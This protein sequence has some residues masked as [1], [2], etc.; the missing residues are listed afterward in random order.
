[1]AQRRDLIQPSGPLS[2]LVHASLIRRVRSVRYLAQ[3]GTGELAGSRCTLT[4]T[5]ENDMQALRSG[6][7]GF[8]FAAVLAAGGVA[9]AEQMK[10]KANLSGGEEV[11]PVETSATGTTDVTYDS[12]T[13]KLTWTLEYSGLS[14]DATAAHFHGP[15][16]PGENADPVVPIPDTAS[17][18]TGEADLTEEQAADLEAGRWYV[19]VHTAANPGGEIRGQVT[20]AE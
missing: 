5:R 3:C 11:P 19:N 12:D 9:S 14:G 6:I 17:G 10:F 4:K 16:D 7:A 13:K 8:A 20:K 18:S 15:A 2:I 1:M